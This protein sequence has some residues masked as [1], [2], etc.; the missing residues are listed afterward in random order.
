MLIKHSIT[1]SIPSVKKKNDTK[2]AAHFPLRFIFPCGSLHDY[3]LFNAR[4]ISAEVR[5]G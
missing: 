3:T 1:N 4:R 2:S 5:N